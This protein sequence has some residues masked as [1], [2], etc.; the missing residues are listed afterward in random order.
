MRRLPALVET[1]RLTL[2]HWTA[3]D[4][5]SLNEAIAANL[6]HLRPFLAWIAQ[7]PM[8]ISE[9]TELIEGWNRDWAAG[10]DSI[11]GILHAER[12]IGG[13]G[14]LWH[15]DERT[16]EIG[17]WIHKDFTRLG[18]ASEASAG[19]TNAAFAMPGVERVEIHHDKANTASSGVPRSLGFSMFE[20]APSEIAAPDQIGIECKWGI[21]RS[22]WLSRATKTT[23][24]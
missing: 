9:R 17:Y 10:G 3:E 2:R 22:K 6:D 19:L 23:F 12:P 24:A 11:Y 21:T 14:L 7:E 13:T 16:L 15:D 1:E 4:V 18:F 20:E 8:S 5:P